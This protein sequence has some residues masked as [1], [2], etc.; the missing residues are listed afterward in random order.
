MMSN[1][2]NRGTITLEMKEYEIE[3]ILANI[4]YDSKHLKGANNGAEV[5]R[6]TPNLLH[7]N[8]EY[9]RV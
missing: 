7:V 8:T 5:K 2:I 3:H 4:L 6:A 1:N 9:W